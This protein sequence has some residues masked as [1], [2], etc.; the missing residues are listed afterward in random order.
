MGIDI[1]TSV[2]LERQ[3]G[4]AFAVFCSPFLIDLAQ[5]VAGLIDLVQRRRAVLLKCRHLET[6]VCKRL[7]K[8]IAIKAGILGIRRL[9]G[10]RGGLGGFVRRTNHHGTASHEHRTGRQNHRTQNTS[11]HDMSPPEMG[12]KHV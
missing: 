5:I 3:L 7:H 6:T 11:A 1:L 12:L 9:G 10:G 4:V 8:G 2:G